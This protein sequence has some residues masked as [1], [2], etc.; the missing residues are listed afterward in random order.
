[1]STMVATVSTSGR[2]SVGPNTTPR[3]LAFIRLTLD[4]SAMLEGTEGWSFHHR[5]IIHGVASFTR[6]GVQ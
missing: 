5:R 4:C 1:M 2:I 3:L 6:E